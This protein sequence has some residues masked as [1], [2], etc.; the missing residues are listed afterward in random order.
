MMFAILFTVFVFILGWLCI[1]WYIAYSRAEKYLKNIPGPQSFPIIGSVYNLGL[2]QGLV[3]SLMTNHKKYGDIVKFMFGFSPKLFVF[4]QKQAEFLLSSNFILDKSNDYD[5]FHSWLG[6]GL[7]TSTGKHWKQQR[8]LLTPAFHFKILENFIK[9]FENQSKILLDKLEECNQQEV[10]IFSFIRLLTLD[11][12]CEATM[13]TSVNAQINSSSK[14]VN[15][16]K[17]MTRIIFARAISSFKYSNFLFQFTSDY[18]KEK[19]ALKVLHSFSDTVIKTRRAELTEQNLSMIIEKDT[20]KMSFLDILLQSLVDG[21]PLSDRS[22]RDEVDTFMFAGQDTV[23][24]ALSFTLYSLAK[25]QDIQDK[26]MQELLSIDIGN[27]QLTYNDLQEMRYLEQVIKETLRLYPPAPY[28]GRTLSEDVNFDGHVL[29][30]NLSIV[31]FNYALHRQESLFP[32]PEKFDPDRFSVE[33]CRVRS[34]YS[35]VP[36]SAGPRNCIGQKFAM[37]EIKHVVSTILKHYK[38]L[39]VIGHE[40]DIILHSI[41]YSH[42]GLHIKLQEHKPVLDITS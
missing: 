38:L 23:S 35:Y 15:S 19:N 17:E 22:I 5:H 39:P 21:E 26:V 28:F 40:P 32:D 3:R 6:N 29:P 27:K 16:V 14:Y 8:K 9:V 34:I 33:N 41:L 7:I 20:K 12:I 31:L 11:V 30:K 18:Q 37:L 36:F 25:Y 4:G 1:W 2:N 24:S 13:K 10:D 42:N